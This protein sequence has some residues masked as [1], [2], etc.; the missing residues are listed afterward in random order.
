MNLW[1]FGVRNPVAANLILATLAIGGII[2]GLSLRKEF[3]PEVR[4]NQVIVA[5]PYPGATPD[6]VERSLATKIEDRVRDLRGVKEVSTIAVE[7]RAAITIEFR[8]NIDIE[9]AVAQVKREVDALQDLPE[10]AERIVVNK[11]EPNIPTISVNLSGEADERSMKAALREIQN[12]LRDLP[13]MGDILPF[14]FRADELSVEVRPA[15]LLEHGL[16]IPQVADRIRQAMAELPGGSVRSS[17]SSVLIRTMGADERAEEVRRVV[18]KAGGSGQ[19]VRVGDIADVREGFVDVDV[20]TRF[21]DR[22]SM[23]LTVYKVG[24]Q[25]AV[26]I[27]GMV[28]AYCAGRTGGAFEPTLG[29]RLA[30]AMRRPGSDDPVSDRMAAFDL[31][32]SRLDPLPGTITLSSDL[33]RFITQRLE[34][35]GRNA[36]TGATMVY[37]TL[38]IM[39]NWRAANWVVLGL[40]VAVLGTLVAMR[41]AGITLN[42][43]TMFGLILVIG[44]LVDDGIVIAENIVY[45]AENGVPPLK[46]AIDGTGEVA[47]PVLATVLTTVFAFM[48]LMLIGGRIGDFLGALPI[49][50][51]CALGVSLLEGYTTLPAHMGHS[52][53]RAERRRARGREGRLQRLETRFD[54]WREAWLGRLIYRPYERLLRASLARPWL[55]LCAVIAVWISSIAMLAGG[56]LEFVFFETADNED[57]VA[58]LRMPIGTPIEET[59]AIVRRIER[60]ALA[61]P[62]VKNVLAIS[63]YSGDLEGGSQAVQSHLAQLFIE[64]DPVEA[65]EA[66]G[67]R[68][69]PDVIVAIREAAGELPGIRNL[70]IEGI[71]GGPGGP[72]ISLAVIGEHEPEILTTVAELQ[73]ILKAFDGVYDVADDADSGQPELR[74]TLLPGA[75]ELGLTTENVARQVRGAVVGLEAH[76]FAGEREDVD[77]RV[78]FPARERRSLA[79]IESMRLFTPGGTPVPLREVVRVEEAR[80]YATIR[81]L[82][83]KRVVLVTASVDA[84]RT[85]TESV[86]AAAKP[87]IDALADARPGIRIVERGRQKDMA[88]SFSTL[89]LGMLVALVLIYVTLAWIFRSYFQ[90]LLIM[91]VIP[92]AA[93]GMIWGH[94]VMGYS[95]T[96]LSLIGFVALAGV[97]VNDAIVYV[98]FFNTRRQAGMAVVAAAIET[99]IHRVRPILL[100]TITT[101]AG[102]GPLMLERSFQAKILIPMA[103]TLSFGLIGS[104]VLVLIALPCLL[105]ATSKVRRCVAVAWTGRPVPAEPPVPAADPLA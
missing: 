61:Q 58:D 42:L 68:T 20:L 69:S 54:G 77:V 45:K 64:L 21:N 94:L 15:A 83:G 93:I 82:D 71:Q 1:T 102:I 13:G 38:L 40:I 3:F 73:A 33:S 59:D 16:S 2:F 98:Q 74:L 8:D 62:E 44:I 75:S 37:L 101:V 95:L 39:L 53:A 55:A 96:F 67:E 63:G 26:K 99:G 51:T 97:V 104:T 87:A 84:A 17:T 29:E 49:V 103:I 12:D 11:F 86:M 18:V 28:K 35:L 7:G 79:A 50:A 48:P 88:E 6:E 81:R 31:G 85:N 41:L 10:Q 23:G 19:V 60:A 72:A 57:I 9:E 91:A 36:V 89:P 100:T 78:R 27:A 92:F 22:R 90:P 70:R 56:R 66:A 30:L 47:W 105:V 76:T 25:D 43:L 32:A 80:G 4:P 34:L 14:G 46:A 65:R 24:D 52:L 5:A